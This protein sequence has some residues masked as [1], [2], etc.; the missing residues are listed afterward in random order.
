MKLG[1]VNA[2]Y[3]LHISAMRVQVIIDNRSLRGSSRSCPQIRCQKRN[4][5]SPQL[6]PLTS[7]F[8]SGNDEDDD[9]SSAVVGCLYLYEIG[10]HQI[11]GVIKERQL[12]LRSCAI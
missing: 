1:P 10:P 5:W 7:R 12:R 6:P 11:G 2:N 3:V 4:A 9:D 8:L